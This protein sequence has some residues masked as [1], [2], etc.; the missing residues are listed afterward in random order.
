[1]SFPTH[2]QTLTSAD[3]SDEEVLYVNV[4]RMGFTSVDGV[5]TTKGGIEKCLE[6]LET[7]YHRNP[8]SSKKKLKN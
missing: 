1:M 5:Q 8:S 7:Y 3:I 4:E 6:R 2:Y